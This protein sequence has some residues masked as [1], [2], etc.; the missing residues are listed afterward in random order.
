MN[1]VLYDGVACYANTGEHVLEE[2]PLDGTLHRLLV[3]PT[4]NNGENAR[5]LPRVNPNSAM[6]EASEG[7]YTI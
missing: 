3:Q 6:A 1:A 2:L 4:F 7:S 5:G